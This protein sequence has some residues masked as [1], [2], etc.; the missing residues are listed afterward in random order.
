MMKK[1]YTALAAAATL[2][3]AA[4]ATSACTFFVYQPEEPQSLRDE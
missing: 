4:V 2:I 3:A 1:L